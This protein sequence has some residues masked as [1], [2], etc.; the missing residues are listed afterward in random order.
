MCCSYG[1]T[2]LVFR[3]GEHEVLHSYFIDVSSDTEA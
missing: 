2:K 3:F 1:L